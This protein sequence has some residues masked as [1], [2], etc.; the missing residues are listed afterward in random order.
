MKTWLAKR[1]GPHGTLAVGEPWYTSIR[2][3]AYDDQ[4]GADA[5]VVTTR[6]KH[7]AEGVEQ[8][9]L[10]QAALSEAGIRFAK[11]LEVQYSDGSTLDAKI[12]DL[13]NDYR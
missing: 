1:Y 5:L 13:V 2:G 8:A 4:W 11:N 10:I 7:D 6:L 12:K 9:E 3:I